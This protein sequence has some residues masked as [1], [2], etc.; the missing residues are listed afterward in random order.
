MHGHSTLNLLLSLRKPV[1]ANL[2]VFWLLS[3]CLDPPSPTFSVVQLVAFHF[4]AEFLGGGA[5]GER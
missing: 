1:Q 5:F 3:L 4:S 2:A